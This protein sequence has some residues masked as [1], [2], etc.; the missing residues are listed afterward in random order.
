MIIQSRFERYDW[1]KLLLR[2]LPLLFKAPPFLL[3]HK[4]EVF[5]LLTPDTFFFLT[6]ISLRASLIMSSTR[7]KK[8]CW[9]KEKREGD[10][11]L[12]SGWVKQAYEH[13]CYSHRLTLR[14]QHK[15]HW[16]CWGLPLHQLGLLKWAGE[17]NA[18]KQTSSGKTSLAERGEER[19][20]RA[21]P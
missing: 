3:V 1:S 18:G 17:W 19:R 16:W 14:L 4:F 5:L 2:V 12:A 21:T 13:L 7:Y 6:T 15:K 20:R 10:E 11:W 8:H 9:W